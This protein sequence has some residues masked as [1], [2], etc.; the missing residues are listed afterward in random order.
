MALPAK[1]ELHSP[2]RSLG[3]CGPIY[4]TLVQPQAQAKFAQTLGKPLGNWKPSQLATSL[5]VRSTTA[6]ELSAFC[7]QLLVSALPLLQMMGNSSWKKNQ[8]AG[9]THHLAEMSLRTAGEPAA[10]RSDRVTG[11]KRGQGQKQQQRHREAPKR[12]RGV[13]KGICTGLETCS[14][15]VGGMAFSGKLAIPDSL[16]GGRN[17]HRARNMAGCRQPP[18]PTGPWQEVGLRS[19]QNTR[20][21]SNRHALSLAR[22]WH[23]SGGSTHIPMVSQTPRRSPCS[24]KHPGKR[25][26]TQDEQHHRPDPEY[27]SRG[28]CLAQSAGNKEILSSTSELRRNWEKVTDRHALVF[29]Q[30]M[31][32]LHLSHFL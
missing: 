12:K 29:P 30:R 8:R 18:H 27:H 25:R 16:R 20:Q 13:P 1:A 28:Q 21:V 11:R 14:F 26:T 9:A 19:S 17:P 5:Q 31:L 24:P 22:V 3:A 4:P 10:Q 32:F 6:G 15:T 7:T 2:L 23:V